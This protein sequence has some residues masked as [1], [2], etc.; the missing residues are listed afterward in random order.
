MF[1]LRERTLPSSIKVTPKSVII[2][3]KVLGESDLLILYL[4]KISRISFKRVLLSTL[5]CSIINTP[6]QNKTN[7]NQ[8]I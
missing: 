2:L 1:G 4:V 7:L 5:Y 8:T 6:L 3:Y